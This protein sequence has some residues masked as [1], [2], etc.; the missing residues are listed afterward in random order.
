MVKRVYL[1]GGEGVGWSNYKG[2]GTLMASLYKEHGSQVRRMIFYNIF[3]L[4]MV[5]SHIQSKEYG[6]VSN[7]SWAL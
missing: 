3:M 2:C 7:V 5:L 4:E 1:T 6:L